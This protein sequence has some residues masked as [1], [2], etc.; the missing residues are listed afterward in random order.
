MAGGS[1][2][3]SFYSWNSDF[4][5]V[6]K[7]QVV[8]PL[9]DRGLNRRG[10]VEIWVKAVFLLGGFCWSLFQMNTHDRFAVAVAWLIAMGFFATTIGVNIQHNGNYGAFATSRTVNKCAGW[11][12]DMIGA[13]T[14]TWEFQH[15]LGHH[16]YTN[17]LDGME[18][19]KKEKGVDCTL[20]EKDPPQ[21]KLFQVRVNVL[22]C[23]SYVWLIS[24][25]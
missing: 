18:E 14:F 5:R 15:M 20:E 11:T 10:S 8:R 1:Y 4:Y 12:L 16:P 22:G 7:R 23:H 19:T 2:A 9:E 21:P 13:S 25:P 17:V 6:L 24:G 3:D